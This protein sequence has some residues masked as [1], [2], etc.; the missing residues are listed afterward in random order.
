MLLMFSYGDKV[1]LLPPK[2]PFWQ[3]QLDCIETIFSIQICMEQQRIIFSVYGFSNILEIMSDFQQ[4][5][6][7]MRHRNEIK[8]TFYLTQVFYFQRHK[9]KA[10][11][12]EISVSNCYMYSLPDLNSPQGAIS[13]FLQSPNIFYLWFSNDYVK[14]PSG[15]SHH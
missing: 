11:R 10:S 7:D 5:Q 8:S 15:W 6:N 3:I 4:L 2:K 13:V 14:L 9:H 1:K 12:V